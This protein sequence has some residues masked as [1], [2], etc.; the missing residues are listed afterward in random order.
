M[1]V[2]HDLDEAIALADRC[3]VFQG[4]PG[5]IADVLRV[6]LPAD[7]DLRTLRFDERYVRLTQRLWQLMAPDLTRPDAQRR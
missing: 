5:T 7:R 3:V 6:D 1:F 2:T 4:R